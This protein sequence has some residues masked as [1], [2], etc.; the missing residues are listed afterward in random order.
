[1]LAI[2]SSLRIKYDSLLKH[3]TIPEQYQGVYKKWLQYYL[4]YCRKY[5]LDPQ[6]EKS[7]PG[8]IKKLQDKNQTKSQQT[9]AEQAIN[10]YYQIERNNQGQKSGNNTYKVGRS[11]EI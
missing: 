8:F 11:L 7:L 6:N 5:E 1:M 9:Q 4:D 3:K 10:L 2:P